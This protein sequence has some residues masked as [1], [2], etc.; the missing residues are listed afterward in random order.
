MND[1][2]TNW[3]IQQEQSIWHFRLTAYAGVENQHYAIE[4]L[5]RTTDGNGLVTY[6]KL[7]YT[8]GS[9]SESDYTVLLPALQNRRVPACPATFGNGVIDYG[10]I[11][12]EIEFEFNEGAMPA[13]CHGSDTDNKV[14][15]KYNAANC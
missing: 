15:R 13:S 7:G 11:D 10:E 14:K 3:Q 12:I 5:D 2:C 9:G 1:T 8:P 4:E 6:I